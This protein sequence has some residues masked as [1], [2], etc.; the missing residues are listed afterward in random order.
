MTARC[1]WDAG[2]YMSGRRGPP[3]RLAAAPAAPVSH[4]A[5]APVEKNTPGTVRLQYDSAVQ[6]CMFE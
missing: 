5:I 1:Y 2:W 6:C 3:G 4:P